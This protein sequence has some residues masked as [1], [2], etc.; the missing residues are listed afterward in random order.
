MLDGILWSTTGSPL[1]EYSPIYAFC[2]C[3]ADEATK[4]C[5]PQSSYNA[6]MAIS[7]KHNTGASKGKK[8]SKAET[9][10]SDVKSLMA[11]TTGVEETEVQEINRTR[12]KT[13]K[14]IK[15][16]MTANKSMKRTRMT[17]NIKRP[18]CIYCKEKHE[19]DTCKKFIEI[20][21]TEVIYLQELCKV[22]TYHE[23]L[24]K[25]ENMYITVCKRLIQ[26]LFMK[27]YLKEP[28]RKK[29][30]N[31]NTSRQLRT[32]LSQIELKSTDQSQE[33]HTA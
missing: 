24:Q 29:L 12:M 5:H 27:P 8:E 16:S 9:N 6:V 25:E 11:N 32:M 31:L 14:K 7:Q 17:A 15:T 3:I 33:I 2:Q 4:A 1:A 19:L 18:Q 21:C 28:K 10:R 20:I 13:N 26:H 22:W 30:R 23:V